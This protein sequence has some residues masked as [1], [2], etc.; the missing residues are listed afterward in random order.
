MLAF[1][2]SVTPPDKP[3]EE[4]MPLPVDGLFFTFILM[5]S[6]SYNSR[7]IIKSSCTRT[8]IQPHGAC[9]RQN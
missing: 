3:A 7:D 6:P 1:G 5:V 4:S 8:D 9:M 2:F